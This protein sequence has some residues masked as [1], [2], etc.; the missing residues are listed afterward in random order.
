MSYF[1]SS[2][3]F[4]YWTYVKHFYYFIPLKKEKAH[5][6]KNIA[7]IASKS[8]FWIIKL[9]HKHFFKWLGMIITLWLIGCAY[10]SSFYQFVWIIFRLERNKNLLLYVFHFY[11]IKNKIKTSITCLDCRFIMIGMF[12]FK[13]IFAHKNGDGNCEVL[14]I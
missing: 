11:L 3:F 8:Y 4:L 10:D 14:L 9:S 6:E 13:C 12:S 1:A 7:Y 5:I 2:F